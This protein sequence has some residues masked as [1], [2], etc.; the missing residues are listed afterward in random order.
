M[1]TK[2][3]S[4]PLAMIM[5][6]LG[7]ALGAGLLTYLLYPRDE[8][9]PPPVIRTTLRPPQKLVELPVVVPIVEPEP[10][11]AGVDASADAD[12]TKRPRKQSR[13]VHEGTI[14]KRRLSAFIRSHQG[15]VRQCYE[16]QLRQ[17]HLLQGTLVAQMKILPSGR[18]GALSFPQDTLRDAQVRQC[19]TRVINGWTFP[20][21][22]GGFVVVSNPFRF[23]PALNN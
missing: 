15:Q 16:R 19:V 6:F 13:P 21:P 1:P 10:E 2:R 18:V 4:G 17:N 5:L 7:L 9:P 22:E 14:D 23:A 12:E 8:P 20:E 3:G 11:D